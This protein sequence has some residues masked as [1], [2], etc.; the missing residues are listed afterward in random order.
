MGYSLLIRD[1]ESIFDSSL[2]WDIYCLF[3]GG[4]GVERWWNPKKCWKR[5]FKGAKLGSVMVMT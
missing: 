1:R 2:F 5:T 3:F 4:S